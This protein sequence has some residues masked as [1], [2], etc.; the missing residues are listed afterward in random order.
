VC[1]TLCSVGASAGL[2]GGDGAVFAKNSDRPTHEAQPL[3]RLPP[4]RETATRTTYLEVEG[5]SGET[6]DV[7]GSGP[8]WMWGLEQGLNVAGVAIGNQRVWTDEDPRGQP[9]ALTGMDLVRLGLERGA[10]ATAALEVMVDLLEQHGQGGPCHPDGRSP[11]WSSFLV[12]DRDQAWALETSGRSW[13]TEE[14][15]SGR[16]ISNRL[17]IP[18]FDAVHHLDSGGVIEG[19]VDPRLAASRAVLAEGPLDVETA[20]AHLR[21]HVGGPGGQT[22][23]M[24]AADEATTA[25]MVAVLDGDRSRAWFLLGSP[26]R[27][28][29]VPLWPGR[30]LGEVPAWERFAA[31]TDD[32]GAWLARL[33]ADLLADAAGDDAWGPE[34]WCRVTAALDEHAAAT[35]DDASGGA[36]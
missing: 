36:P 16:A 33:E 15:R 27:S 28:A 34:A 1:D 31:L 32:D 10:T 8:G 17:T 12:A 24:H 21:T 3:R 5:A 11:Y 20:M 30:T 19:R 25:S 23:C 29:Y 26:C 22:I 18:R 6:L 14:V 13:A 7:L 4:R 35:V 2:T 9:A